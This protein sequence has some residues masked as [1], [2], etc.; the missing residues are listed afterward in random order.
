[1][2][3]FLSYARTDEHVATEVE[4]ALRAEGHEVF[5][6]RSSL[7][8]GQGFHRQ[9]RDE[10]NSTDALVYALTELKFA[11]ER[12]RSPEGRVLPVV[13]EPTPFEDVPPYLR[14]VTILDPT[15]NVAAEIAAAISELGA[16]RAASRISGVRVLMHTAGFDSHHERSAIFVNV[17]NLFT[18][19]DVEVTHVWMETAPKV[20]AIPPQRPL[21]TRLRPQESWETWVYVDQLPPIEAESVYE[22]ARV[23]LSTGEVVASSRNTS[24]PEFGFVPGDKRT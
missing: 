18:E 3:I 5:L 23:R 8:A 21:P 4:L 6:D 10:I 11:Q 16:L 13:V 19:Q 14:A 7:R 20:F 24:V 1:M 22:L 2:R 15:G 12:W 17:T 9:I